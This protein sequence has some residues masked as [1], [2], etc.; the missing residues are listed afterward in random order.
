VTRDG[1]EI[2]GK[3]TVKWGNNNDFNEFTALEI[4]PSG[5]EEGK[6]DIFVNMD[7]I[8]LVNELHRERRASEHPLITYYFK[9][10]LTLVALSMLQ[11]HQRPQKKDGGKGDNGRRHGSEPR[12]EDEENKGENGD[13][14]G[15]LARINAACIGIAA[16]IIPVIQRLS[17]GPARVLADA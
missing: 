17:Q 7:N 8:H 15:Y 1:R 14:R 13:E 3:P 5:E 2:D 11:E 6:Y 12:E 10:G 9:Y 16:V 4:S